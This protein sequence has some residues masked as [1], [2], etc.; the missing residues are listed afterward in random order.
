MTP[1][2]FVLKEHPDLSKSFLHPIPFESS[3]RGL[4]EGLQAGF[5]TVQWGIRRTLA[6]GG[7]LF[8]F[9]TSLC[10]HSESKLCRMSPK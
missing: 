10:S 3:S 7:K 4:S 6:S 1:S 9:G 2:L 8:Q 5:L